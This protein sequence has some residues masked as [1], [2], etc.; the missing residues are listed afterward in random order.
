[1]RFMLDWSLVLRIASAFFCFLL[2]LSCGQHKERSPLFEGGEAGAPTI[3]RPIDGAPEPEACEGPPHPDTSELCGN[4]IV[5]VVV[6][7]PNI[8]F[9]LDVSGSMREPIEARGSVSKLAAVKEV[10]LSLTRDLGHRI[11][12]GLATFPGPDA[13][14]LALSGC[15]PGRELFALQ[16]GDP[17]E[18]LN[19]PGGPVQGAF[20]QVVRGLVAGGGTPLAGTLTEL[21]PT[22]LGLEGPTALV[23]LTDGA[24]NCNPEASCDAQG[25]IPNI[26]GAELPSGS[27]DAS[28]NCCDSSEVAAGDLP[29]IGVPEASCADEDASRAVIE[30][31]RRVGVPS[32]V[33]GVPGSEPYAELMS[34]LAEA[35][36]TARAGD[37]GY[38]GVSDPGELAEALSSI[39]AELTQTCSIVLDEPPEFPDMLNVYFDAELIASDA[40]EGWQV[41]GDEV[42]FFG[43]SCSRLRGGEVLQ[44]QLVSGCETILY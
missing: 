38:Y 1:M 11:S 29:F 23:V 19:R 16:P 10:L 37:I 44:V 32:Y 24:P 14:S 36:G 40:H 4:Q 34:G 35:G 27:C 2:L 22:I 39:G 18:C 8:Y 28:F 17:L 41:Q 13:P 26:E 20:E 3:P 7:K 12:Y 43:A 21:A 42:N 9:V 5:P 30:Q 6:Q 25:C 31:L 15:G 33:I